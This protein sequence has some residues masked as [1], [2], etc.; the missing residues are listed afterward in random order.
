LSFGKLI[1]KK[2]NPTHSESL[3]NVTEIAKTI[4]EIYKNNCLDNFIKHD[5]ITKFVDFVQEMEIYIN[6]RRI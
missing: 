4:R 5:K 1:L 2:L 6:V 3:L